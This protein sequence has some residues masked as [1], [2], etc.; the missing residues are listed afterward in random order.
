MSRKI[1]INLDNPIIQAGS[2]A[3]VAVENL[4]N[5]FSDASKQHIDNEMIDSLIEV[6]MHSSF[7]SSPLVIKQKIRNIIKQKIKKTT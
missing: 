2:I 7:D 6:A 3:K 1:D 4:K 5:E